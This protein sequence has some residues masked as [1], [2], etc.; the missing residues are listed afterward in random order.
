MFRPPFPDDGDNSFGSRAD[1]SKLGDVPL[2]DW[3][4]LGESVLIR[5]YNSSGV[6]AYIGET[7]FANGTWVGVELDA[8]KGSLVPERTEHVV[9]VCRFQAK[10][11]G[12]CKGCVIS[13]ANR[14]T[15][16]SCGLTSSSSIA[17]GARWDRTSPRRSPVIRN[18]IKV[19]KENV[20][21]WLV[22]E[23]AV[24]RRDVV[25][26]ALQGRWVEQHRNQALFQGKVN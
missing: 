9:N 13:R 14:S 8:P 16:C 7:E 2:P 18:Q 21:F 10:M 20:A 26:V 4:V 24:C 3:V 6:V 1:L 17:G 11:T 22:N 15:E 5:P 25:E 23:R 12:W 19:C